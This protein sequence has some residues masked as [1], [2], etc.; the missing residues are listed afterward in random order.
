MYGAE[1]SGD[2]TP[3]N[4]LL[5]QMDERIG[6]K[7]IDFGLSK[8][9]ISKTSKSKAGTP[10]YKP[11]EHGKEL[12]GAVDVFAFGGVLVYLFGE[13]HVHPFDDLD[14]EGVQRMMIECHDQ[15]KALDV[16]ELES[17]EAVEI[18]EISRQCLSTESG[19]RP[20]ARVLLDRFSDMCGLSGSA[21]VGSAAE[22][23]MVKV[24]MRTLNVLLEEISSLK[25][26]MA[27]RDLEANDRDLQ[28]DFLM[29]RYMDSL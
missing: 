23:M 1:V 29:G 26:M 7:L 8:S 28:I 10:G 22:D 25:M 17:I 15:R 27:D 20:T 6:A 24:Q 2:L 19:S 5:K 14:D 13:E 21:Q 9:K 11:P 16:P 18:R 4:V 12:S 3:M